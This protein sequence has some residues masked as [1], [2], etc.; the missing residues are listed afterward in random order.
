MHCI[1]FFELLLL[2]VPASNYLLDIC[3]ENVIFIDLQ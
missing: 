2:F 3:L 1:G